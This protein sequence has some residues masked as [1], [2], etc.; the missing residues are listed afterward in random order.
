MR[1]ILFAT[2][3]IL[4]LM[5]VPIAFCLFIAATVALLFGGSVPITVVIQRAVTSAD[6]FIL[7]SIPFFMLAGNLMST[8]GISKKIMNVATSMVGFIRGGLAHVNI[9]TSM[10]FA[11]ITGAAVADTSAI[12]SM[13][14]PAMKEEG[15]GKAFT[16]AVTASSSVIGVIIPPSI[17]FVIY[18][19]VAEV[20]IGKLFLGGLIPGILIGLSQ[21]VI[22]Y[23]ISKNR[24]Y[25]RKRSFNLSRLV[26]DFRDG[27]WALFMPI[28]ILGGIV[29]GIVTP[30]EA[31][32]LATLYA[33]FVGFFIHRDLKMKDLPKIFLES[34]QTTAVVMF[35]IVGASLYGLIITQEQIPLKL[36]KI[37]T[38]ISSD[39]KTVLF[40]FALVY[41]GA[42][43]FLD[44]GAAIILIVP[45]LYPTAKLIGIDPLLLGIITV[46]CLAAG[47]VTP[48]VGACL[49][50]ACEIGGCSIIE[51]TKE[52]IPF[53]IAIFVLAGLIILIPDIAIAIPNAIIK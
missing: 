39:P 19:V 53:I 22:S 9:V 48:P 16:V 13:I 31:S 32:V 29:L 20:S 47:L 44:L 3:F 51:A 8:G 21:M 24:N 10:L 43:L 27:I 42:G 41:F 23:V 26:V 18:G 33:L 37:I 50:I 11:G 52:A 6:T 46:V 28:I 1:L 34:A 7:L 35:M 14:I 25:G 45:I 15:Y 17:P 5:E 4:L 36:V 40:M 49:F 12:G 2:F 30:T 38:S